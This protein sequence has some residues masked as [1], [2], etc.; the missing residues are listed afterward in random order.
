MTQENQNY[1]NTTNELE[2][3]EVEAQASV[4]VTLPLGAGL[5]DSPKINLLTG[6]A[7]VTA[8][9]TSG[10]GVMT[11]QIMETTYFDDVVKSWSLD[12]GESLYAEVTIPKDTYYLR[13]L[14]HDGGAGGKGTL[15]TA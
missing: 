15:G 1:Q 3:N 6:R 9:H 8:S 5:A 10:F 7:K 4:S 2:N 13:L 11:V 12:P 14:S